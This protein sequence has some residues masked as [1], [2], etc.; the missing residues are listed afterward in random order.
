M[1]IYSA[2]AS[3]HLAASCVIAERTGWSARAAS[4]LNCAT[5]SRASRGARRH[6][7][8]VPRRGPLVRAR[9]RGFRPR[10]LGPRDPGMRVLVGAQPRPRDSG[11]GSCSRATISIRV[12]GAP[13]L[14]RRFTHPRLRL[15]AGD[16]QYSPG[17][18]QRGPHRLT[19]RWMRRC[20]DCQP[21]SKASGHEF[22]IS[23]PLSTRA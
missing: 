22:Y 18:L 21:K 4:G 8:R 6:L 13:D 16:G 2:Y 7:S 1:V 19:G 11:S 15:C 14:T 5:R 9:N 12:T 17:D 10:E 20:K 23:Q 3:G